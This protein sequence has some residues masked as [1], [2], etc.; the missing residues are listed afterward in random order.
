MSDNGKKSL[1]AQAIEREDWEL[2]AL[3]LTLGVV[4]AA[5]RLPRETLDALLDELAIDFEL[6][7]HWGSRM[8]RWRRRRGPG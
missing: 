6:R 4:E 7:P 2:A 3:C 5:N 1:L 8:R